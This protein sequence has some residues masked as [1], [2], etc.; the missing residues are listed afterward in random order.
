[1][2]R[3]AVVSLHPRVAR[4]IASVLLV[5]AALGAPAPD[6]RAAEPG[7]ARVVL[8]SQPAWHRPGD[9]IGLRLRVVNDGD[10][11]LEGV[12]LVVSS[13]GRITTRSGLHSSFETAPLAL[14]AFA[15]PLEGPPLEPGEARRVLVDEP[16]SV[17]SSIALSSAGGV[18]PVTVALVADPVAAEALDTLTTPFVFHPAV[19]DPPL[20]VVPVIPLNHVATR[21]PSGGFPVGDAGSAPLEQA[22]AAGGWLD[23][24]TDALDRGTAAGLHVGLAPTPRLLEEVADLADGFVRIDGVERVD[25]GA[26]S[27]PARAAAALLD[28]L[29]AIAGRRGVQ[30]LL[31]PYAFADLPSLTARQDAVG[32][33]LA[34]GQEVT[35]RALGVDGG[36]RW[37]FAPAA[38]VDALTADD[39]V[40]A[41]VARTFFSRDSLEPP[42]DPAAAGCPEPAYSFTCPV[43]AGDLE[44]LALDRDLQARLAALVQPGDDGLDLQRLLAETALVREEQ[45]GVAGR[46]VTLL[47]PS[48]WRPAPRLAE[49]FVDALRGAPW[50]RT[51]APQEALAAGGVQR[52]AER[53]LVTR[54]APAPSQP[55]E[56]YL[57][58][59]E[60]AHAEVHAFESIGPPDELVERLE[61]NVL[62]A[63]SRSWWD[64]PALLARGAGYARDAADEATAELG[65]VGVEPVEELTLTSRRGT[66][67]LLLFNEADYAVTVQLH[68]TSPT[69]SL[70][71]VASNETI[72]RTVEPH[73]SI[74]LK[75]EVMTEASGTFPLDVRLTTPDGTPLQD[76]PVTV[77]ST[78]FNE[79]ALAVTF[80]ALAFLVLFYLVRSVRKRRARRAETRPA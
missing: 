35:A 1:M 13:G 51:R 65:K 8:L 77:R 43:D 61:R 29:A 49:R 78:V 33:Q 55:D 69:R 62:V 67:P 34:V 14:D 11:A 20:D 5:V 19:P 75:V 18:F 60:R 28:R 50:L 10:E 17:L 70:S 37:L 64:D 71:V 56:S 2:S 47:V 40:L 80:G 3:P 32:T 23:T 22:V 41:G 58:A 38:R 7:D 25:V 76:D 53:P 79:I 39:L 42:A 63:Q 45:P 12:Q 57:D 66:I 54:I 16:L 21:A 31:A 44:G 59:V 4:A 36:R 48:Q 72:E 73:E 6:A 74:R 15:V 9:R 52:A 27:G 26:D 68:L 24:W 30:E 46:V